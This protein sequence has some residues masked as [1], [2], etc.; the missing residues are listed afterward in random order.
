MRVP[1]RAGAIV[2]TMWDKERVVSMPPEY[3]TAEGRP[4]PGAAIASQGN[5]SEI[6]GTCP[7]A[8]GGNGYP[9]GSPGAFCRHYGIFPC[10]GACTTVSSAWWQCRCDCC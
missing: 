7:P 9:C 5:C 4:G 3:G 2:R 8:I 10:K 6:M 1:L